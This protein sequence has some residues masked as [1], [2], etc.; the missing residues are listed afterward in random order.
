MEELVDAFQDAIRAE[1]QARAKKGP[2]K[3][4]NGK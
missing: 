4:L 3:E 1:V 2:G